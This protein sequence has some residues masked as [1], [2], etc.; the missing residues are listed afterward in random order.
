MVCISH[1]F[2][3]F[4]PAFHSLTRKTCVALRVPYGRPANCGRIDAEDAPP[5]ATRSAMD[6]QLNI[7]TSLQQRQLFVAGELNIVAAALHALRPDSRLNGR[8]HLYSRAG[9]TRRKA[10]L[11]AT[12]HGSAVTAAHY[13]ARGDHFVLV[14]LAQERACAH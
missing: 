6:D 5:V 1:V 9:V 11:P 10:P 7:V 3:L 8:G 12:L 13:N 2:W 4:Q 14:Y